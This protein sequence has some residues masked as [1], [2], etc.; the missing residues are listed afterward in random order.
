MQITVDFLDSLFKAKMFGKNIIFSNSAFFNGKKICTCGQTFRSFFSECPQ[1]KTRKTVRYTNHSNK[2]ANITVAI[3]Y[4]VSDVDDNN[5]MLTR[6]D[7]VY[8]VDEN[9]ERIEK[10]LKEHSKLHYQHDAE[11]VY[12]LM[13]GKKTTEI[14]K[15][16]KHFG[17]NITKVFAN[18]IGKVVN[19]KNFYLKTGFKELTELYPSWDIKLLLE[20]IDYYKN[21]GN[22]GI[23]IL[24]KAGFGNLAE[25]LFEKKVPLKNGTR[26]KDFIRLPRSIQRLLKNRKDYTYEEIKQ[27]EFLHENGGPLTPDIFERVNQIKDGYYDKALLRNMVDLVTHGY[28]LREILDYVERAD[29]YQAIPERETVILLADYVNMAVRSNLPYERFPN[30]LKK[31][32]DLM[33]REF[34]F[35]A[36]EIQRREFAKMVSK[37]K[38]LEYSDGEYAI[39][40]PQ[41]TEDLVKEGKALR[42]CVASYIRKIADGETMVVFLRRKESL[43]EPF[44]TIEVCNGHIVQVKGF[45]NQNVREAGVK[46]FIR[47]W[48]E[49]KGLI[50]LPK[51]A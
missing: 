36:D 17:R 3:Y 46:S 1:C 27:L 9:A 4:A 13:N 35:V 2:P 38:H 37:N 19:C 39:V 50:L 40:L 34:K 48:A 33:A 15:M 26:L 8:V 41:N 23:E 21:E 49:K 42:H 16:G 25:E 45:A 51:V 31:A 18:E 43:S 28:T 14:T 44:Y 12:L 30:S 29:L 7:L 47:K 5:F 20:Y 11:K 22:V 6:Y 32:H 10:V 24:L